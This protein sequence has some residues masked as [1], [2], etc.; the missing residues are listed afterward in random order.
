MQMKIFSLERFGNRF[1]QE[2]ELI[3]KNHLPVLDWF[4]TIIE[5][6]LM[7]VSGGLYRQQL[8]LLEY[9]KLEH[10]NFNWVLYP[11]SDCHS[12]VNLEKI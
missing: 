5:F 12:S 2:L 8:K 1:K 6:S 3:L 9:N 7:S 4:L 11:D 10:E